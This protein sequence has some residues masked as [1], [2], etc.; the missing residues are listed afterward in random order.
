M[1]VMTIERGLR[2]S[3]SGA[4]RRKG[5][6]YFSSRGGGACFIFTV[7]LCFFSLSPSL[8]R[9]STLPLQC[10]IPCLSIESEHGVDREREAERRSAGQLNQWQAGAVTALQI[11]T[12]PILQAI[13]HLCLG[14]G[15]PSTSVES[16]S[17]LGGLP[18]ELE[19]P[20]N[21]GR[22]SPLFLDL[23]GSLATRAIFS[24]SDSLRTMTGVGG[25]AEELSEAN[26]TETSLQGKQVRFDTLRIGVEVTNSAEEL[27][28]SVEIG[29]PF[30]RGALA[31]AVRLA[32]RPGEDEGAP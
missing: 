7:V 24:S 31:G 25:E 15:V 17:A 19:L 27:H 2:G 10:P 4:R 20:L 22:T 1:V 14:D 32:N 11:D 29:L 9:R 5:V 18:Q 26:A 6:R 3:R 30:G 13:L 23:L 16:G 28:D 21:G 12:T 8:A